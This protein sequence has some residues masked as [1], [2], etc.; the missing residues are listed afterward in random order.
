MFATIGNSINI[1]TSPTL[2]ATALP[3]SNALRPPYDN[4]TPS[5]SSAKLDDNASGNRIL[6]LKNE[7]IQTSSTENTVSEKFVLAQSA[8]SA[9]FS[10][11]AQT[12]FLT[13]LASGDIS[14]EVYGIF[15]QYDKLVSYANVKYKPSNAGKPVDPVTLFS[16]LMQMEKNQG[17]STPLLFEDIMPIASETNV[18]D[19]PVVTQ[20][21]ASAQ[22][23]VDDYTDYAKYETRQRDTLPQINAYN[24]TIVRNKETTPKELELA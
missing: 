7:N 24:A 20:D 16:S 15:V 13:Q 3:N 10:A 22:Y 23:T 5:I 9:S 1:P 19:K 18:K 11:N 8:N 2:V 12:A 14:P 21:Q 17:D 6:L 4:V